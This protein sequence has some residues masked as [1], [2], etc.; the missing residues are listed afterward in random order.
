M[1][2][3]PPGIHTIPWGGVP[4]AGRA[5]ATVGWNDAS[6][7][8]LAASR[9]RPA[10]SHQAAAPIAASA[11][12]TTSV[13]VVRPLLPDGCGPVCRRFLPRILRS[14]ILSPV[15]EQPFVVQ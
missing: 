14:L 1:E 12:N 10:E 5:F 15:L 2:N 4:E 7:D 8:V 11:S 13:R 3:S 6:V 9:D